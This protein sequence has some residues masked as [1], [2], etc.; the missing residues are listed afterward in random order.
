MNLALEEQPIP[1]HSEVDP[2]PGQDQAVH[3]S[4]VETTMAR[5]VAMQMDRKRQVALHVRREWRWGCWLC[6]CCGRS[7][8][9]T[10]VLRS[11]CGA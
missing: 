2:R 1:R 6:C 10:S 7:R 5:A 4:E 9:T 11:G 8:G 3:A